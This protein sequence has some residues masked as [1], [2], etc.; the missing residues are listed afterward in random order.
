MNWLSGYFFFL[1]HYCWR[2]DCLKYKKRPILKN[3]ITIAK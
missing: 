2:I 1:S 3:A